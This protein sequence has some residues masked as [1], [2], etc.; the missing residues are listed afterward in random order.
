MKFKVDF[1]GIGSARSGSTWLADCLSEHPEIFI[2][3]IKEISFFNKTVYDKNYLKGLE[4]YESFFK[5]APSDLLKGE[6]STQYMIFEEAPRLIRKHFPSVKLLVCLRNPADMLH[7]L[8]WWTRSTFNVNEIPDTFEEALKNIPGFKLRGMY[9]KQLK[10]YYDRFDRSKIK[11]IL[12]DD[13]K[14]KP[15][16]ILEDVYNYLGV[17]NSF[18]PKIINKKI[19]ICRQARS[20]RLSYVVKLIVLVACKLNVNTALRSLSRHPVLGKLYSLITEKDFKYLEMKKSTRRKI[21]KMLSHDLRKLERLIDRDLK[22]WR[23]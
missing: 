5:N 20:K 21:N 6:Y 9:F 14:N 22:V 16:E 12:H 11:V 3:R 18:R 2:P 4:W 7:S 17:D 1:I 10:P 15:V 19:N 13:I 23:I 8:Y